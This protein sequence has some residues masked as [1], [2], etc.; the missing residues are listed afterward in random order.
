M[1]SQVPSF[2]TYGKYSSSNYGVNT[3]VFTDADGTEYYFSYK[4]LVAVRYQGVLTCI[5]N[6]WGSTTGK[7]LNWIQPDKK[8]R[9]N[10]ETF[11]AIALDG[12]ESHRWAETRGLVRAIER[13]T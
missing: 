11:D 7:H 9:V 8:K 1:T 5:Q 10:R 6:S 12:G 13:P 4:T 2:A 3:L